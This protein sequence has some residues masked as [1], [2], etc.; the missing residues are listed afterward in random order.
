MVRG[1]NIVRKVKSWVIFVMD[2][3]DKND[4]AVAIYNGWIYNV[5]MEYAI[6]HN[7]IRLDAITTT[8][9]INNSASTPD[10]HAT[11]P[12]PRVGKHG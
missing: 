9:T 6:P 10:K 4:H 5:N 12:A 8:A 2:Y 11:K 7:R 3:N 1:D